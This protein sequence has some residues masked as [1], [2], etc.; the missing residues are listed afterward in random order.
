MLVICVLS[1]LK[2]VASLCVLFRVD[3]LAPYTP[4]A[5]TDLLSAAA[6]TAPMPMPC[7]SGGDYANLYAHIFCTTFIVHLVGLGLVAAEV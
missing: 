5:G 4:V 6:E 3:M 2:H 7:P 1:A